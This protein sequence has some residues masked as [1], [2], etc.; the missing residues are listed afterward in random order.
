MSKLEWKGFTRDV[1]KLEDNFLNVK[2]K[3][4]SRPKI[5]AEVTI[6]ACME[7]RPNQA[8]KWKP[9]ALRILL[10]PELRERP[11]TSFD[12]GEIEVGGQKVVFTYQ[13]GYF[14]GKDETGNPEGTYVNSYALWFNDG[15][16]QIRVIAAYVDDPLSSKDD[17]VRAVPRAHLEKVARAFLDQ[18]LQAWGN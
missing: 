11:D 18:Y 8:D 13:L 16:N 12:S 7:C 9:D 4:E 2:H 15:I 17:L 3:T 14:F 5:G 6:L 10:P 1:R